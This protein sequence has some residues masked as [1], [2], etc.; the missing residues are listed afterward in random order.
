MYE[1]QSEAELAKAFEKLGCKITILRTLA[2]GNAYGEADV[3]DVIAD[4]MPGW[5]DPDR[6]NAYFR[7]VLPQHC[8]YSVAAC[9]ELQLLWQ[10]RH[11][12]VHC[13][14]VITPGDALK[15]RALRK[16]RSRLLQFDEA[17]F[18]ALGRRLHILVRGV[19]DPLMSHIDPLLIIEDFDTEEDR[20]HT[21]RLIAGYE[22]PRKSWFQ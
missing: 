15:V 22:S 3:G 16:Y 21:L 14:N 5:H 6:V 9:K 20:E 13:G 10:L 19:L 2:G 18:P 7:A 17:F 11:S 8:F 1:C 12:I 4:S